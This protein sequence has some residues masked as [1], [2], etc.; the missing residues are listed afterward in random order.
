VKALLN[1]EISAGTPE[2]VKF[3]VRGWFVI[4]GIAGDLNQLIVNGKLKPC[5]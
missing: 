2:G 1:G 4:I 5:F 3:E